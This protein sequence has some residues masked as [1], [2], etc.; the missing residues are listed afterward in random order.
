MAIQH[1]PR[2]AQNYLFRA[3]TRQF[4]QN[5]FGAR[6][7]AATALIL[8]PQLP[9]VC[10]LA[11]A[12]PV[13]RSCQ[14]HALCTISEFFYVLGN[15]LTWHPFNALQHPHETGKDI[16]PPTT[17]FQTRPREALLRRPCL[18]SE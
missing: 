4:L 7:D 3:K 9:K 15:F 16:P 11:A 6:Q 12:G 2:K 5:T 1:N 14:Y 17:R 10:P 18:E 8:N 13:L